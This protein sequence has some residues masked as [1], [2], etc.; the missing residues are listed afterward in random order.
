M[1]EEQI[2][3]ALAAEIAAGRITSRSQA[4]QFM[5]ERG[6]QE[7]ADLALSGRIDDINRSKET[8]G[9]NMGRLGNRA[10]VATQRL[11][12]SVADLFGADDSAA[13]W[14]ALAAARESEYP[15]AQTGMGKLAGAAGYIAPDI[16]TT[17]T[18]TKALQALAAAPA[19]IAKAPM[20]ARGAQALLGSGKFEKLGESGA[21]LRNLRTLFR[22]NLGGAAASSPLDIA[23]GASDDTFESPTAMLSDAGIAKDVP[24]L[25]SGIDWLAKSKAGRVAGDMTIGALGGTALEGAGRGIWRGI[26]HAAGGERMFGNAI[27]GAFKELGDEMPQMGA[28]IPAPRSEIPEPFGPNPMQGPRPRFDQGWSGGSDTPP[29]PREIDLGIF[30]DI[31]KNMDAPTGQPGRP[32][33]RPAPPDVRSQ[34]DADMAAREQAARQAEL[35]AADAAR[36]DAETAEQKRR[37]REAQ[38]MAAIRKQFVQRT[39]ALGGDAGEAAATLADYDRDAVARAAAA[40]RDA[41]GAARLAAEREAAQEAAAVTPMQ[42]QARA[43]LLARSQAGQTA[44]GLGLIAPSSMSDANGDANGDANMDWKTPAAIAGTALLGGGFMRGMTRRAGRLEREAAKAAE[45]AF[46]AKVTLPEG[47][48]FDPLDRVGMPKPGRPVTGR[49]PLLNSIFGGNDAPV[50]PRSRVPSDRDWESVL[51]PTRRM[52]NDPATREM[53]AR[54]VAGAVGGAALSADSEDASGMGALGA[55]VMV[56]GPAIRRNALRTK[57]QAELASIGEGFISKLYSRLE[58]AVANAPAER[59]TGKQWAAAVQKDVNSRETQWTGLDRFLADRAD[60][61]V[62][63]AEIADFLQKNPVEIEE[64]VLEG[65]DA[66]WGPGSKIDVTPDI[67]GKKNYREVVITFRPKQGA[68]EKF[69]TVHW[70]QDNPILH[71]R[72]FDVDLPNGERALFVNEIQ[73]DL[74]QQ[75]MQASKRLK[76]SVKDSGGLER[77]ER[78]AKSPYRSAEQQQDDAALKAAIDATWEVRHRTQAPAIKLAQAS[79]IDANTSNST[80][81]STMFESNGRTPPAEVMANAYI[82][83][84]Q[85]PAWEKKILKPKLT[86]AIQSLMHDKNLDNGN[87]FD[88]L[89]ESGIGPLGDEF[90]DMLNNYQR[91]DFRKRMFE[92]V[93]DGWDKP[94]GTGAEAELE[95]AERA[96]EAAYDAYDAKYGDRNNNNWKVPEAPFDRTEDWTSLAIRRAMHEATKGNYDRIVFANGA[97]AGRA[98]KFVNTHRAKS[99]ELVPF[100]KD[101]PA[102]RKRRADPNYKS[103]NAVFIARDADGKPLPLKS[104]TPNTL[105]VAGDH[106]DTEVLISMEFGDENVLKDLV[107]YLPKDKAKEVL[108]K[109]GNRVMGDVT[110]GPQGM[111]SYYDEI[112][113]N[114]IRK[115]TGLTLEPINVGSREVGVGAEDNVSVRLTPEV[116][117]AVQRGQKLMGIGATV[118]GGLAASAADAEAQTP[119]AP[120]EEGPGLGTFLALGAGGYAVK[121]FLT[122]AVANKAATMA[123][124][125]SRID[126]AELSRQAFQQASAE[127]KWANREVR[128]ARAADRIRN[129]AAPYPPDIYAEPKAPEDVFR[130]AGAIMDDPGANAEVKLATEEVVMSG[131]V[132]PGGRISWED[133]RAIADQ[134]GVA[135]NDLALSD[136]SKTLGAPEYLALKQVHGRDL[137]RRSLVRQVMDD[138]T[139]QYSGEEKQVAAALYDALDS[140][141]INST[142]RLLRDNQEK[143]RALNALKIGAKLSDNP[144]DWLYRATKLAGGRTL[145][146]DLVNEI[147][148]AVNRQDWVKAQLAVAKAKKH[149]FADKAGEFWQTSLLASFGRVFRDLIAN[150]LNTVDTAVTSAVASKLDAVA[151]GFG[152]TGGRVLKTTTSQALKAARKNARD[153]WHQ[154][155]A[156]LKGD[157]ATPEELAALERAAKRYDFS[158]ET[159]FDNP[160]MRMVA[161]YV[162]RSIGAADQP[163]YEAGFGM[164]IESMA[165]A[166]ADNAGLKGSKAQQF[167]DA[168]AARPTPQMLMIAAE[169]AAEAVWQNKT[170]LGDATQS[171]GLRKSRNPIARLAG[172]VIL[173]FTQTPSAMTTDAVSRTPLGL[174]GAYPDY[175]L[176]KAGV[177]EARRKLVKKLAGVGTGAAWIA[178]GYM[179]A[180]DDKMTSNYPESQAERNLW[181][182]TGRIPNAIMVGGKWVATTGLLG[183]QAM[184]M[185]MGAHLHGLMQEDAATLP[186]KLLEANTAGIAS[187]MLE[188]PM[189]QGANTVNELL[190][191]TRSTD[192]E[193]KADARARAMDSWAGGWVPRVVQQMA[194]AGDTDE[195][196]RVI[197]RDPNTAESLGGKLWDN[198]AMGIPGLRD[199]LPEKLSP[200]G[201]VRTS[202]RGGP[203]ALVTPAR[204]SLATDT[205]LTKALEGAGDYFP[206]TPTRDRQMGES[207]EQLIVRRMAEG[208]EERAL[209]EG[210]MRGN[211]EALGWVSEEA[212]AQFNATGNMEEM[213]RSALT[214]WRSEVTRMRRPEEP[215]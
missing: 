72:M 181:N 125:G 71:V 183:P 200:L 141:I 139:G 81:L 57:A 67:P 215:Q 164:S 205:P 192:P 198:V 38:T 4:L 42:K 52:F 64:T 50:V 201:N 142:Q 145:D 167:V 180:D 114:L 113:P 177:P 40:T 100:F 103:T 182:E 140:R 24:V 120:G 12:G 92:D 55:A 186:A 61:P 178:A 41:P 91:T 168:L 108:A 39:G 185:S 173:P 21:M 124:R 209:L 202:G 189:M 94:L 93:T 48:E 169:E 82:Y 87:I 195:N 56:G 211:P 47:I 105:A 34:I 89:N 126:L 179:L 111:L 97:Q 165:R 90:E 35:D 10:A 73:S 213:F 76:Q 188:T 83:F 18:G 158:D 44:A 196:G 23:R 29:A 28:P 5:K 136:P 6:S 112:V 212:E 160:I 8:F 70:K 190:Q 146:I 123:T 117:T 85:L 174:L 194:Q 15:D 115:E 151:N 79:L 203:L 25:G 214:A 134:L 59:Q 65:A 153:G 161:T 176:A 33:R 11:A 152:L 109:F 129:P 1:N 37:Y 137:Q 110:V 49:D 122:R 128:L 170:A 130:F 20:L 102:G 163:F 2:R 159:Q 51:S 155:L 63:K 69:N 32:V 116:K 66:R 144:A 127:A 95:A 104:P 22:Q 46:A 43:A 75:A 77:F 60:Q 14:R 98:S 118:G 172:K 30:D 54:G 101:T 106:G 17:L 36:I 9:G 27:D 175:V 199:N 193:R 19:V 132:N 3:A 162:R 58:T 121:K 16:A 74:H 62:T 86:D 208:P 68:T 150:S 156:I 88:A 149:T 133:T 171:V 99:V 157:A 204:T 148:G 143:G 191:A 184:L 26:T 119:G 80:K 207:Q 7:A 210:I 31:A 131:A 107:D 78:A 13:D 96:Q 84:D 138:A 154:A 197:M 206:S 187:T 147:V 166:M 45:D 135:V 53:A